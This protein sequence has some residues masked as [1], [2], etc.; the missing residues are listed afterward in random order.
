MSVTTS[1]LTSLAVDPSAL[2]GTAASTAVIKLQLRLAAQ[3]RTDRVPAVL[4][5]ATADWLGEGLPAD[6]S[7]CR[8][9]S[10]DL[11]LRV[12]PERHAWFRKSAIVSLGDPRL[13]TDEWVVPIEWRAASLAPLFPVLVGVLRLTAEYLEIDGYYAPPFGVL[14][15]LGD[16][17]ILGVAAR[18]TAHWFLEAVARSLH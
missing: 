17:L 1:I 5:G 12:A 14:G 2:D 18:G 10:C 11:Q 6:D 13:D 7:G 15:Y 9:F 8:R 4:G 3:I 16:R